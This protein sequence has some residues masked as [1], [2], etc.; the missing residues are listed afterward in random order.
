M[1]VAIQFARPFVHEEFF[2]FDC[3]CADS[4]W[5]TLIDPSGKLSADEFYV[6]SHIERAAKVIVRPH[7]IEPPLDDRSPRGAIRRTGSQVHLGI[8]FRIGWSATHTSP[9]MIVTVQI[10][11]YDL[12]MALQQLLQDSL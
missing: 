7:C 4:I 11:D 1:F 8:A 2:H 3:Q 12:P 10:E 9:Y 6:F 5:K